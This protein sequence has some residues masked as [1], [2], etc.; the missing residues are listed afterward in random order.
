MQKYVEVL[1]SYL[2]PAEEGLTTSE[3]VGVGAVFAAFLASFGIPIAKYY[4]QKA[5]KEKLLKME[6]EKRKTELQRYIVEADKKYNFSKMS[7]QQY[8][9][10]CVKMTKIFTNDVKSAL[11][12]ALSN[13]ILD[14]MKEDYLNKNEDRFKDPKSARE[15]IDDVLC[16]NNFTPK[17]N[18]KYGIKLIDFDNNSQDDAVELHQLGCAIDRIGDALVDAIATKYDELS[19]SNVKVSYDEWEASIF[20]NW[21]KYDKLKELLS[22]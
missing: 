19:R 3:K 8:E 6:A 22:D 11:S 12:K 13:S 2:I 10:F 20:F 18:G 16:K 5:E 4:K 9:S 14:K 1:E 7:S 17:M 21:M 15:Y